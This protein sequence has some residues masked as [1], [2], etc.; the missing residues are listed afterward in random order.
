MV[1]HYGEPIIELD[2]QEMVNDDQIENREN[3]KLDDLT[4]EEIEAKQK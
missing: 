2:S 1:H 4:L 3:S